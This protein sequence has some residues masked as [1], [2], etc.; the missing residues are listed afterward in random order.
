MMMDDT[1]L[2]TALSFLDDGLEL[3]LDRDGARWQ[4]PA[5]T[6]LFFEVDEGRAEALFSEL[7]GRFETREQNGARVLTPQPVTKPEPETGPEEIVLT[8][9]WMRYPEL[10][11]AI[12]H[13][14]YR[15]AESFVARHEELTVRHVTGHGDDGLH[16]VV[17]SDEGLV[18]A[19]RSDY[20]E[21]EVTVDI[22]HPE[23]MLAPLQVE[24][25]TR[26]HTY[27][28]LADLLQRD[29][30][31]VR[32]GLLKRRERLVLSYKEIDGRH[33]RIVFTTPMLADVME[34]VWRGDVRIA[35]GLRQEVA[36]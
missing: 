21:Y 13:L 35:A 7:M 33:R 16:P 14:S 30:E 26:W 4:H 31:A 28:Q 20:P 22:C 25:T 9:K 27:Y 29:V 12:A 19:L 32:A 5:R 17:R 23:R 36:A 6:H 8:R 11:E 34:E 1:D 18:Q 10:A 2:D 24:L 3:V 15:G